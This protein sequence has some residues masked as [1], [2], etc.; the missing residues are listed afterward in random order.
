[1][2]LSLRF[3]HATTLEAVVV[4]Q[5]AGART[6]TRAGRAHA[7]EEGVDRGGS[8]EGGPGL[9][10]HSRDRAQHPIRMIPFNRSVCPAEHVVRIN[11]TPETVRPIHP[12]L[13]NP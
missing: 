12:P 9:G 7:L 13:N 4:R 3:G 10:R 2:V 6:N 8:P 11:R 5:N 1:M